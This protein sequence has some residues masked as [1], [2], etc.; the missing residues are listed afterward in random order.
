[1]T[2]IID[3]SELMAESVGVPPVIIIPAYN[4]GAQILPVLNKAL[5]LDWPVL[6]VDDGS[7]DDTAAIVSG[8]PGVNVIRHPKNRGKGAAILT[9]LTFAEQISNW[10][11]TMDADGQHE[12]LDAPKLLQAISKGTRPIVV[13]RREGMNKKQVP[14]TSRWG[15]VFSNFWVFVSGGP[16]LSDSQSG[17]RLYP[18]PETLRLNSRA[19]RFQFEVEIVVLA[20]WCGVPVVETGVK[21]NY[22]SKSERISHFKP[23]IDFWR[24]SVVFTRL[25]LAR[26]LLSPKKRDERFR[27]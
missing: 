26:I 2:Q 22:P 19:R 8:L 20:K 9:G 1:M 17:Y 6:V 7:T 3:K 16:W 11:V 18:L 24:N 10:A 12:P 27:L 23:W 5:L 15:R 21:V 13:G 14:G 25:I 4:H